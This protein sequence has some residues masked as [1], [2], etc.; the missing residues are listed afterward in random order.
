MV[1]L[2]KRILISFILLLQLFSFA[3]VF[4]E[5]SKDFYPSTATGR[6]A[7]LVSA[8]EGGG[9][10]GTFITSANY[11]YLT[12]AAH[13]AYVKEG[14]SITAASSAQNVGT[15]GGRIILTAPDGTVYTSAAN[16]IGKIADR[17][18]EV[19]GA[20]IGYTSFERVATATQVGV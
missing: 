19:S 3:D 15:T 14:E 16:N 11:P 20:R 9:Y 5:G 7:V 6:R 2:Y 8:P 4:A 1:H 18:A 10:P 12:Q 17:T 13:F